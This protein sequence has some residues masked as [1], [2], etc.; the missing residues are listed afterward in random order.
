M[1]G[2]LTVSLLT[3]Q[4]EKWTQFKISYSDFHNNFKKGLHIYDKTL[5]F[6]G[7][8][9]GWRK[10]I[11]LLRTREEF[12]C[13]LGHKNMDFAHLHL[14]ILSLRTEDLLKKGQTIQTCLSNITPHY[15]SFWAVF[16]RFSV[17]FDRHGEF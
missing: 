13:A 4:Y 10:N 12:S 6:G 9:G 14:G 5:G 1:V 16:C 8:G 17:I 11:P 15:F 2:F 7:S 3:L